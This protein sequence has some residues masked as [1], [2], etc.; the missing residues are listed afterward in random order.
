M[1]ERSDDR[2]TDGQWHIANVKV[3]YREREFTFAKTLQ[4]NILV[5]FFLDTVYSFVVCWQGEELL[6]TED[7]LDTLEKEGSSVAVVVLPGVQYYTGQVFDMKTIT[8]AAHD[9]VVDI[10][11]Q[12]LL[13]CNVVFVLCCQI[14]TIF[15]IQREIRSLFVRCNVLMRKFSNCWTVLHASKWNFSMILRCGLRIMPVVCCLLYTSPSPR[16]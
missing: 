9:K 4:K 1:H 3:R 13:R 10:S 2:Q 12:S 16:D 14:T 11:V 8:K 5:S 6:S 7:I 15:D